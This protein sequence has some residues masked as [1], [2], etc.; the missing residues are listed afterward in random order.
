M[1]VGGGVNAQNHPR[2]EHMKSRLVA[3]KKF[4]PG[5]T[6]MCAKTVKGYPK[7]RNV[8]DVADKKTL[9]VE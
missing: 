2:E 3:A 4:T 8:E 9:T 1:A 6:Y 7:C 5:L